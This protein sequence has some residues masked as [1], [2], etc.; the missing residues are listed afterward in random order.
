MR[1]PFTVAL[2]LAAGSMCG[3]VSAAAFTPGNLV[4]YRVGVGGTTA[5]TGLGSAVFLDEYTTSGTLIQSLAM[6]TVASSGNN[7]FFSSGT[8]ITE[9]FLTIS[10]DGNYIVASGYTGVATS[11]TLPGTTSVLTPRAIA[12][13]GLNGSINNTTTITDAFSGNS[14][15][16]V[17][18]VDGTGFW[19]VGGN[20]GVR[21]STLGSSTST[22]ISTT[23]TNLRNVQIFGG[24]LYTSGA[25]G[26]VVRIGTVGTG[27]PTS[28][29]Q[30][31]T[32]L[33]GYLTAGSPYSYILADLSAVV[34][35]PDTLYVADDSTLASTPSGGLQKYAL[36]GGSWVA[37]GTL[38]LTGAVAPLIRGLTGS[39]APNGTDFN[40]FGTTGSN[41]TSGGGSLYTFTDTTGYN[42]TISGSLS[43]IASASTNTS[44][45]GI[46]TVV[47]EP[48]SLG[49]IALGA[50]GLLARRRKRSA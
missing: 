48:T 31:I 1:K 2:L 3:T 49:L 50:V 38:S 30:T 13:V 20:N 44:F 24:Q 41:T 40:L 27:T 8:A 35:G 36:V 21:Y 26:S 43:T 17:A 10:A 9:G 45:R 47:P 16:S 23:I 4:I 34:A 18:S 33:P 25:S 28:T 46:V 6:P 5:L 37:R 29:G 15:R 32:N 14:I 7:A 12:R 19:S 11:G 39:V 42:G 22:S